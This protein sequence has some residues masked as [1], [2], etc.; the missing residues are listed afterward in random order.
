M[1]SD[2]NINEN[3]EVFDDSPKKSNVV[4]SALKWIGIGIILLICLLLMYRCITA[5][6]HP[7]VHKV[8]MNE[9]FYEEYEKNPEQLKV[10]KYGMQSAWE[11]VDRGRIVEF[12]SLY[13]I[14]ATNQL[15]FSIKY[16]HD[17]VNGEFDGIP[18]KLRLVDEEGNVYD[19]YWYDTA[20]RERFRYIRV[21]FEN[22]ELEKEETD[23][24][25]NKT[26]HSYTLEMDKVNE[27]GEYE[28][29]CKYLLFD[30]QSERAGVFK[31]VKYEVEKKK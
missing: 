8:L 6:N 20:S 9:A 21:C 7:I 29:L 15:Q 22:I 30:G 25:G 18:F 1:L 27:K 31:D 23:E 11:S 14:P 19:E 24:N 3:A 4:V 5:K 13:H 2:F 17:I 28:I 16:N 10:R 26:Y 12:N